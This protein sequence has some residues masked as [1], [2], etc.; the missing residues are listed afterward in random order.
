[1]NALENKSYGFRY[2]NTLPDLK[3][4]VSHYPIP[5]L[6]LAPARNY[7]LLKGRNTQLIVPYLIDVRISRLF[8]PANVPIN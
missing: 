8:K 3:T 4:I 7:Y 5:M 1:M 6:N 2:N